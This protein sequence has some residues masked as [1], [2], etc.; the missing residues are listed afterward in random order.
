V[1]QVNEDRKRRMADRVIQSCGGSVEGKTIAVL[2]V[3]FKPNTDDVRESPS[4]DI[5]PALADAGARIQAF[6]PEGMDEAKTLISGINWCDNAY[7]AMEGAD[8]LMILTEWNE[9]RGLDLARVRALLKSPVIVD[10][11]NIYRPDEMAEAG[12][13]YVSIGR[14]SVRPLAS[15][16]A[17]GT[18]AS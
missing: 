2:G 18:D 5:L 13:Q 4:I 8:A 17:T 6:D 14:Q 10:L 9:F 16:A 1:V 11:R 15:V 12:F 7:E 3:T